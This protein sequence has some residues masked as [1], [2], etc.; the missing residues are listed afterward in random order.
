MGF[1][2]VKDTSNSS[3]T[4]SSQDSLPSC[5]NTCITD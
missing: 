5:S 1:S 4:N 3:S 2:S